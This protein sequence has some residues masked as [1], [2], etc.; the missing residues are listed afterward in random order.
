MSKFYDFKIKGLR[1]G[2]IDFNQFKDKKVLL[3]NTASECGFTTQYK[4]LEEL[5]ELMGS[6]KFCILGLPCNDFG[7]QEPGTEKDISDFCEVNYGVTFLMTEKIHIKPPKTHP[8]YTWLTDATEN[9]I[10]DFEVS[11][12]FHKFL[13]DEQGNLVRDF[14]SATLPIDEEIIEIIKH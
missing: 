6:D 10:N 8:L 5:H 11:W 1:E 13:I 14:P 12:N 4:Q 2:I 9:G 7:A 3:V